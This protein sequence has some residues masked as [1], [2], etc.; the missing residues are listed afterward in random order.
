MNKQS[1]MSWILSVILILFATVALAQPRAALEPLIHSL[2]GT[3]TYGEVEISPEG[4]RVAWSQ[5]VRDSSGVATG[6]SA[7]YVADIANPA[8]PRRIT[9]GGEGNN[10]AERDVAWSPDG[11]RLAFLSNASGD[12]ELYV[13]DAAGG[14]ARKLTQITGYLATPSWSPDG[15]TIAFLFIENAPRA[16]GPL[17][18][19]T[20]E[21]GMIDSKIFEQRLATVDV[22]SGAVRQ[23][24]PADMYVYEYSWSPDSRNFALTAAHGA[25]DSNWYV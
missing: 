17:M 24:S 3:Q 11:K 19:M 10:Y 23:L 4:A 25:G 21:T 12:A 7:I 18:P 5:A 15:K 6:D 20:P 2:A 9:A 14:A 1:R 16:A 8:S 13:A 22:A